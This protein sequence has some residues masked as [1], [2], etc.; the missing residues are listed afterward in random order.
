MRKLTTT[1]CLI[2]FV[3]LGSA[4]CDVGKS[5]TCNLVSTEIC[6][7]LSVAEVVASAASDAISATDDANNLRKL[8]LLAEQGNANS[9]NNLGELYDYGWGV[10]KDDEEAV[11][12]YRLAAE[13]GHASAQSNLGWMYKIGRGIIK[14]NVHAHMWFD[15]AASL[16]DKD[17]ALKNRDEIA[18]YMTS[19]QIAEAQKLAR[20]CVRKKYKGC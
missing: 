8:E 17:D 9:Q 19:A 16:G 10:P 4:G 2:L 18:R 13:Q 20:E 11:R 1:L 7:A 15:I 3:V 6:A 12:W 14:E 5:I